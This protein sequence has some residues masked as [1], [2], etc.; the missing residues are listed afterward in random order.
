MIINET[1][2]VDVLDVSCGALSVQRREWICG[3][4]LF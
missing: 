1:D 2:V 4:P 3:A